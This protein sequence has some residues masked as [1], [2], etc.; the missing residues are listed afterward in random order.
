MKIKESLIS[1]VVSCRSMIQLK[2]ADQLMSFVDGPGW[3]ENGQY[4]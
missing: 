3:V 2:S 1:S 4:D